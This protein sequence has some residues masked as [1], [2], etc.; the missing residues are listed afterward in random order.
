MGSVDDAVVPPTPSS[1][2]LLRA[3]PRGALRV[4]GTHAARRGVRVSHTPSRSRDRERR[5][6][7]AITAGATGPARKF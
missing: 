3:S 4:A 1:A 6:S 7:A 2:R 5:T